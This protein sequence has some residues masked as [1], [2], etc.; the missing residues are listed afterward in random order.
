MKNTTEVSNEL[1]L[2]AH[3]E[4]SRQV[5]KQFEKECPELFEKPKVIESK[6][7]IGEL[8]KVVDGSNNK[9][10]KTGE[11]R[12]GIAVLFENNTAV[13]IEN[14]LS[15]FTYPH[16]DFGN[17]KKDWMY[18]DLLLRFPNGTEVYTSSELCVRSKVIEITM[19]EITSKYGVDVSQIKIKK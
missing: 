13:V 7:K 12:N 16:H 1:I 17:T 15:L 6:F 19:D 5:A 18:S 4:D 2:Q 10:K 8:V 3:K 9:D 11:K 14:N